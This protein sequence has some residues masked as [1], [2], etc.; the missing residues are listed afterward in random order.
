M[1]K[2][3]NYSCTCTRDVC[4]FKHYIE[5]KNDRLKVK[6]IYDEHFDRTIHNE[7]DPEGVRHVPCFFGPLC[8]KSECNFK[9]FCKFEF[10]KEIMNKQ[11]FKH[12]RKNNK[13]KLLNDLKSKYKIDDDDFEK[14]A[15]M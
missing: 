5:D 10:R 3:C 6:E 9:H 15:K 13:D 14:L 11:W 12:S 8:G 1:S 2:N 4:D 7:T